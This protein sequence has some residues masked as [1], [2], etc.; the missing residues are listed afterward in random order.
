MRI[1]RA[2]ACGLALSFGCGGP[3]GDPASDGTADDSSAGSLDGPAPTTGADA[4]ESGSTTADPDESGSDDTATTGGGDEPPP[5]DAPFLLYDGEGGVTVA[6]FN[7][8][9][10][11]AWR[12]EH[13]DWRDADGVEQGDV[14]LATA[15][16]PDEDAVQI[17][18]LD[19]GSALVEGSDWL[20]EG[21][22]LRVPP[23]GEGGI[24]VFESREAIDASVRPKLVLGDRRGTTVELEPAADVHVDAST[25]NGLG[26]SSTWRV[27]ASN[28]AMLRFEPTDPPFVP[29][30]AKLV[31]TTTAQYGASTIGAYFLVAR[32]REY[33]GATTGLAA[34]YP[35]DD[36]IG[37]HPD[38]FM[39]TRFDNG[40]SCDGWTSCSHSE[41]VGNGRLTTDDEPPEEGFEPLD[42]VAF[43]VHY[44]PGDLGGG[45]QIYDFVEA[46][47]GEQDDVYFRYYLR[48]GADFVPIVDGGKMPG[49]SG[50]N[51]LCGNGGSPADGKCG[52][53]LRGSFIH[54]MAE[55]N[56]LFPGQVIGT[57][58]YHG[59]MEGDYGDAWRWQTQGLGVVELSRWVCVEQHVRVNTPGVSDGVLDV[60]IDGHP[61]YSRQDV[62]LRDV[63]PYTIEGD[64]GVRKIWSNHYHGG[65][66]PTTVPLTLFMDN[67][68]VAKSRI[69]CTEG[70]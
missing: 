20:W 35:L 36:G 22:L 7:Q 69:G 16:V 6:Y 19:L 4:G 48:F 32:R 61:A 14:A 63:P 58:A 46:G 41:E 38:V 68:V 44:S 37:A 21:V 29:S 42:G 9:A 2:F 49:I 67:V 18:E 5:D 45:S 25:S 3:P 34:D 64:L 17:V 52:W 28:N 12:N 56:P 26:T 1:D 27:S 51:T 57:Y 55:D 70:L 65:T 10:A 50:D 39:A 60:W 11:L 15:T 43:R 66:S 8:Q 31:L 23:G 13:G 47:H 59:L 54:A 33:L 30:S 24:A 40:I 53:T 62:F